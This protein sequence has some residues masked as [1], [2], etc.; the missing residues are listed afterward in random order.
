M[1]HYA[2]G[3]LSDPLDAEEVTQATFL[4][5]YRAYRLPGGASPHLNGLLAIAYDVCRLRGGYRR[6]EDAD[7]LA[8]DDATTAG[9]V[10]RA[11]GRLPFDQRAVLVMREV[12]G[13][14]YLDIAEILALSA[15]AVETLVFR[16]RQALREELEGA[17]TCHEAELAVSRQLDDRLSRGEKRLL[18][19]H[20]RSC[21]DCEAFAC[22]QEAQRVAIRALAATPLPDT[23]QCFFGSRRVRM[24]IAAR[25]A[26]TTALVVDLVSSGG[27]P[28]PGELHRAGAGAG[29]GCR[30]G[31]A[32][33]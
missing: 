10:R 33:E 23:L 29:C 5:A 22:G 25:L 28:N 13:R 21:D 3:V 17:L 7:L 14:S 12:D 1:Y 4:N 24:R 18:Q 26:G 30:H 15:G 9:D 16:A 8:E 27:V 20:L 31:Q 19:V 11:L 2:L 6:L 32:C